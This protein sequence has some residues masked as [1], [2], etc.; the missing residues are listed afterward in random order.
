[1][2]ST[3]HGIETARRGLNAQ[4]SAL[5]TTAHNVANANTKGYSRQRV[6]FSTTKPYNAIF[7]QI[8]TGVEEGSIQRIRDSFLD[9]Q[10][11][12]EN[13][14]HGFY[15]QLSAAL[16][17]ME[18]IM[19]EPSDSGL[20][21]VMENF[22]KALEDLANHP[23]NS[24]ARQVVASTGQMV[25]ETINYY[26]NSLA[27][28]QKDLGMEIDTKVDH[29]NKLISQIDELNRQ[30]ASVEPHGRLPNDLYDR[31]DLLV[32]ELSQYINIKVNTVIPE[33]YGQHPPNAIGLYEIEI[34]QTD[35]SPYTDG[36]G[37]RAK[38][39]SVDS[40]TGIATIQQLEVT[41]TNAAGDP[42][43]GKV[44]NIQVGSVT[45]NNLNFVG[46][47]GGLIRGYGYELTG[48]QGQGHFPDMLDRL[49]NYAKVFAEE[50]NAVHK[51]GYDLSGAEGIDF[52]IIDDSNP[53]ASIHV[54]DVIV[55]DPAKIA[56][57]KE[58]TADGDVH[59]G[60]NRNALELAKIKGKDFAEFISIE[61]I[62]DLPEGMAA[63]GTLDSYYA[64][65][66]GDLGVDA[67]S[68]IRNRDN[69]QVL[70]DSV[71]NQRQSISAVSLDEELT[72][73]MMF[74]HAYN[75][76]SRMITVLDE[77]LDKVINGMGIVGR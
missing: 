77:V 18:D 22:W 32:D 75:A 43:T 5:Y 17:K 53:A 29:I 14:K 45:I 76:S 44:Q 54:N 37:N 6:N 70:L 15:T 33:Q 55:N 52:F 51:Q 38:L 26:Y 68:A 24:G 57:A 27:R 39:L 31:R 64:S 58:L 69:T 12:L 41:G 4:R 20:H 71:H 36:A 21:H 28:I 11:R 66:I 35:G 19:N 74:Q 42:L 67:Q 73:M 1:M 9:V 50:F 56:A 48:E 34:I 10:Y 8:G 7:G 2:V 62:E 16:S 30:I 63:G 65:M 49:N 61:N 47:L 25:A 46:E 23:E 59:S 3:F 60:D 40:V 13:S 72:N